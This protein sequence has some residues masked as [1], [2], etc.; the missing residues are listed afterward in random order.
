[1][2][3]PQSA[4]PVSGQ[5]NKLDVVATG[6]FKDCLSRRPLWLDT[7]DRD[8]LAPQALSD[9][10]EIAGGLALLFFDDRCGVHEDAL[11]ARQD[12]CHAVMPERLPAS[13]SQRWIPSTH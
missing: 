9:L 5:G 3:P 6:M 4:A 8:S 10:V 1:N 2:Q 11:S 7:L 13:A 12:Q